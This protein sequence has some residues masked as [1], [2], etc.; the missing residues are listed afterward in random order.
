MFAR[1]V[2]CCGAGM[3]SR[4]SLPL[5]G[6]SLA[7]LGFA[8]CVALVTSTTSAQAQV[9]T[10]R[11]YEATAPLAPFAAAPGSTAPTLPTVGYAAAG[12]CHEDS[13]STGLLGD[14]FLHGFIEA[15]I[16]GLLVL[17]SAMLIDASALAYGTRETPPVAPRERS[18]LRITSIA[19][20][21]D[22]VT[23]TAALGMGGRF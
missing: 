20:A 11:D 14:C 19:P 7:A 4:S 10:T 9:E 21:Y 12:T 6:V 8:L 3:L 17:G 23:R 18:A 13:H 5:R 16:G 22:P 15:A 1:H 2:R